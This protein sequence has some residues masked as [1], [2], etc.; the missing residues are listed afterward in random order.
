MKNI[1]SILLNN[2][3]FV[4]FIGVFLFL[5]KYFIK[6]DTIAELVIIFFYLTLLFLLLKYLKYNLKSFLTKK[7]FYYQMFIFFSIYTVVYFIFEKTN[8]IDVKFTFNNFERVFM[9]F[10]LMPIELFIVSILEELFFRKF[11]FN[12]IN[13]LSCLCIILVTSL[14]FSI[15][16]FPVTII[17][18][19]LLFISSTIYG[20]IYLKTKNIAYSIA[21][22]FTTN[23][24]I[25]FYGLHSYN[26]FSDLVKTSNYFHIFDSEFNSSSIIVLISELIILLYFIGYKKSFL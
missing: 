3:L 5:I 1:V 7:C 19:S 20:A 13:N 10:I 18:F 6:S 12:K 9:Y 14:L 4:L 22:H 23:F 2:V 17:E 21:L 25:L 24:A 26:N 16:H 15:S 11:M 8:L